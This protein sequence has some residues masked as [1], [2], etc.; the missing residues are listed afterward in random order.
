MNLEF[1]NVLHF[2][3]DWHEK[4]MGAV[5]VTVIDTWGSLHVELALSWLFQALDKWKVQFLW[6]C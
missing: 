3:A 6:V 2:A 1:D 4:G 5:V